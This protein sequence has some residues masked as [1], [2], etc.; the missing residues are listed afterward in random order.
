[1]NAVIFVLLA[2]L[3]LAVLVLAALVLVVIGIHRDE[4][5]MGLRPGPDSRSQA[6]ARHVVGSHATPPVRPCRARGQSRR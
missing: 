3:V 4:R 5:H 6:F 1:M 2:V